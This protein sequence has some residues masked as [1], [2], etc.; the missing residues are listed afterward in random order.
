MN[1]DK[2][3][4]PFFSVVIP[5]YNRA[6][7]LARTLAS[8][9]GQTFEDFE[10]LIMDDGSTDQTRTIVERFSDSR[11]H[12][13]WSENSGGPATPRNHGI[14]IAVAEWICFLDADDI[15]YSNKLEEIFNVI[16]NDS[17]FDAICHNENMI[18]G[19]GRKRKSLEY[20]P[21]V[22]DFYQ[23][24]LLGGNRCSTSAMTVRKSFLEENSL[25]FNVAPDYVIVEDFDLWLRM[26]LAGARFFFLK[27]VLGEYI[28]EKD[29]ISLNMERFLHN[30]EVLLRDH[31]YGLQ[32]FELNKD[33]L[34]RRVSTRL[35]MVRAK[36]LAESRKYGS[37]AKQALKTVVN[38]P[39]CTAKYL[40][41]VSRSRARRE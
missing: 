35:G 23:S 27:K 28:I 21:Y 12:Y 25:R 30:Q 22:D 11:I 14:D 5:T 9:V 15:W 16:S 32:N 8:V 29:N 33:K 37:A 13:S 2:P 36:Q 1:D 20:G 10:V 24:M 26:A 40:F 34:W 39:C 17:S 31:V 4:T 41:M 38:Y 6:E 19:D 3:D 18:D 7:R